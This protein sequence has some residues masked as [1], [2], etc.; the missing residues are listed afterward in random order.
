MFA[1]YLST[2]LKGYAHAERLGT[3][4]RRL[5][6]WGSEHAADRRAF[7]RAA[8]RR[9]ADRLGCPHKVM[10]AL[11]IFFLTGMIAMGLSAFLVA[12][13]VDMSGDNATTDADHPSFS[14]P[15]LM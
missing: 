1:L 11:V 14:R 12:R 6:M 9:A 15:F 13:Y 5:W 4:K 2:W 8:H 3:D 7:D 10:R